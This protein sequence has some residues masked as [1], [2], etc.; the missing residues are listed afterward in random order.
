MNQSPEQLAIR[1]SKNR[2]LNTT[3]VD[4]QIAM[5]KVPVWGPPGKSVIPPVQSDMRANAPAWTPTSTMRANAPA[6]N[7]SNRKSRRASRKNRRASRKNRR[8]SRKS[9]IASSKNRR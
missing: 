1:Y 8:A 7:P 2:L 4:I 5:G 6:W 9:R 3:P